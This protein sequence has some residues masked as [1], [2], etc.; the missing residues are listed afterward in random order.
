MKTIVLMLS[1]LSLL[2]YSC[3]KPTETYL[4]EWDNFQQVWLE[5]TDSDLHRVSTV[6]AHRHFHILIQPKSNK[7]DILEVIIREGRN[8]KR[9]V[10][11]LTFSKKEIKN[12]KNF[13]VLG[14]TLFVKG[15]A[16]FVHKQ[17]YKL[18][19]SRYFNGWLQYPLQQFKDS[20]YIKR[21]LQIH[22][23]GGMAQLNAEGVNY[24][25]ELT[26]LI[27]GKQINLMKIAVYNIPMDSVTINSKSISYAWASPNAKRLGIN[28]RNI[29]TGWTLIE[30]HY[31][32]SN[33]IAKKSEKK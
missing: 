2:I 9:F 3:T 23:Q 13:T 14:D 33:T 18:I 27:Y 25:V 7:Q 6:N 17:P 16:P 24:T 5:K 11:K 32:N 21:N 20:T 12:S 28:L 29:V 4:G 8:G 15:Q 10:E 31:I 19:R 22:D 1:T 26:Q 30:P